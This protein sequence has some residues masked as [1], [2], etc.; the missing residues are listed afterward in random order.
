MKQ[1]LK[2]GVSLFVVA[3]MVMTLLPINIL[4]EETTGDEVADDEVIVDL[5]TD[6]DGD[7]AVV[8]VVEGYYK[9]TVIDDGVS[10]IGY[11]GLGGNVVIPDT[12]E[13]KNVVSIG[14]HA[15]E[16]C[17]ILT[18]ITI[19]EKV[20]SIGEYAFGNCN[21]LTSIT[22][23]KNVTS[24]GEWA[25]EDCSAMQAATFEGAP[26]TLGESVFYNT[27]DITIYYY[28][29]ATVFPN[30][31]Y[32]YRTVELFK[33]TGVSLNTSE[34]TVTPDENFTLKA[35]IIPVNA[36]N[37]TVSWSSSDEAIAAVDQEG[38]VTAHEVGEATITATTEDGSKTATC[39]V[40]VRIPVEGIPVESVSLN[41]SAIEVIS[42][43]TFT[44][45]A[46]IQP[47]NATNQEVTWISSDAA[48]ASVD[49]NGKVT[50][51]N[52]GIVTI[53]VTTKDGGKVAIVSVKVD[54]T[55]SYAGN[56]EV[57]KAPADA[58]GNIDGKN[59]INSADALEILKYIVK[60][61]DFSQ[62]ANP[63]FIQIKANVSGDF[64]ENN[65]PKITSEDALE[66][67]QRS[68]DL[69]EAFPVEV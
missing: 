25:F 29:G 16:N 14:N 28:S 43:E 18:S 34:K 47:T 33:V 41:E 19:P 30:P 63:E 61:T 40:T 48:I 20:T 12:L 35:N 65:Q 15:F 57:S 58:F 26:P 7:G 4:A 9:Y 17:D 31:W 44:L 22:I 23:P 66:I 45:T 2:R 54:E 56:L 52:G 13:G 39:L 5:G 68:V 53:T 67:L 36:T 60:F 8:S 27:D 24:I 69:I 3:L 49:E 64:D 62:Y 1:R 37:T 38:K 11:T 55:I 51:K 32:G 6:E 10:I 42:G 21:I 59:G 46:S 50:G